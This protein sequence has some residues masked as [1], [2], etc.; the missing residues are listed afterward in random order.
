MN[1]TAIPIN[2]AMFAVT[3]FM[4]VSK[5][6]YLKGAIMEH[7]FDPRYVSVIIDAGSS[8]ATANNITL[9]VKKF[10]NEKKF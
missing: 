5:H 7:T 9:E 6:L 8:G 3:S 2:T 4:K 10:N 1:F